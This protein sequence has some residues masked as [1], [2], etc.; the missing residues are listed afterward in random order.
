ML[1]NSY[2]FVF[3]FGSIKNF[4]FIKL[5]ESKVSYTIVRWINDMEFN[6]KDR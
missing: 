1:L 6:V 5:V 2:S 4:V 3:L